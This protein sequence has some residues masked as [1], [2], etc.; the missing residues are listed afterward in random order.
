MHSRFYIREPTGTMRTIKRSKC[1]SEVNPVNCPWFLFISAIRMRKSCRKYKV[2]VRH[3]RVFLPIETEPSPTL[4]TI[5]KHILVNR[6]FS[7]PKVII[8]LWI[9]A[10]IGY[11]EYRSCRISLHTLYNGRRQHQCL[12][13]QKAVFLFCHTNKIHRFTPQI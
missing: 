8:S 4:R 7:L 11:I 10:Y 3:Y 9:I 6:S 5:D 2:L 12:F 1:S 13:A